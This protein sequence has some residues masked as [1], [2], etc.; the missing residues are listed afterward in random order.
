MKRSFNNDGGD[1]NDPY[2]VPLPVLPHEKRHRHM[3]Y[4]EEQ[5]YLNE[6]RDASWMTDN[7]YVMPR[8]EWPSDFDPTRDDLDLFILNLADLTT[9]PQVGGNQWRSFEIEDGTE[10]VHTMRIFGL[11]RD[12]NT[13][14]LDV[15]GFLP[16]MY[17]RPP[18]AYFAVCR[19]EN[20]K[21]EFINRLR[22]E[23]ENVIADAAAVDALAK[24]WVTTNA[25]VRAIASID[26]E[27][28]RDMFTFYEPT[29][30]EVEHNLDLYEKGMDM[31]AIFEIEDDGARRETM[32][33]LS[34]YCNE[35]LVRLRSA[36]HGVTSRGKPIDGAR[37]VAGIPPQ[38]FESDI[39]PSLKFMSDLGL[40]GCSWLRVPAGCYTLNQGQQIADLADAIQTASAKNPGKNKLFHSV[41]FAQA[42]AHCHIR[43][44]QANNNEP[45]YPDKM[46][47]LSFDLETLSLDPSLHNNEVTPYDI[48]EV[49]ADD[50]MTMEIDGDEIGKDDDF[51]EE[52]LNARAGEPNWDAPK[53]R[54]SGIIQISA[55]VMEYPSNK[56][57]KQALFSVGPCIPR[58]VAV[59]GQDQLPS[60]FVFGN[61]V[62]T[63]RAGFE[64][65]E[66]RMLSAFIKWYV[67]A[68]P[69]IITGYNIL[70]FD[71]NYLLKRCEYLGICP[72]LGRSGMVT[73][74]NDKTF[75]TKAMGTRRYMHPVMEGRITM[76]MRVEVER[77]GKKLRQYTLKM[78][79]R[80]YLNDS[81]EVLLQNS[82]RLFLFC[83]AFLFLLD[84]VVFRLLQ[85][86]LHAAAVVGLYVHGCLSSAVLAALKEG[87]RSTHVTSPLCDDAPRSGAQHQFAIVMFVFRHRKID[88]DLPFSNPANF[89]LEGSE[90]RMFVHVPEFASHEFRAHFIVALATTRETHC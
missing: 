10:N 89:G 28:Q 79:S 82:P 54:N 20:R 87:P 80:V 83:L 66:R 6:N 74:I 68:D 73:R 78:V 46:R 24:K 52:E 51:D 14:S 84:G 25:Q 16:Y 53:S 8:T 26:I 77:N 72:M 60:V 5:D 21:L 55:V 35:D 42:L 38:T 45:S 44:V 18:P 7:R 17:I 27:E 2:R 90:R 40:K 43:H 37:P 39:Q 48:R 1:P 11:T 15:H 19:D 34:F 59:E 70:G 13:V 47:I 30:A 4:E 62:P 32:F 31:N 67:V 9:R 23:L 50:D 81:K 49:L 63:D 41:S 64:Y 88:R 58:D 57:I 65:Q 85:Q 12:G 61:G 86:T 36:I 56:I 33:K 69:D 22:S 71:I 3:G 29:P 75:Q 76:D